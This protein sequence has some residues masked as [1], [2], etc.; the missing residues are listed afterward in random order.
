MIAD[1][2]RNVAAALSARLRAA[3]Y[4]TMA[5]HNGY[6]ALQNAIE[7]RPDLVLM[8]IWMPGLGLAVARRLNELRLSIPV[9]LLTASA[10]DG[11]RAAAQQVGAAALVQKPYEPQHLLGL[12]AKTLTS[13]R[14][15]QPPEP[16]PGNGIS[17]DSHEEDSDR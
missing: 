13:I 14:T 11:L 9:I 12:V 4:E 10:R 15:N 5:V 16:Q 2:D 7:H 8:D 1:D 17:Q 3:G 6:S